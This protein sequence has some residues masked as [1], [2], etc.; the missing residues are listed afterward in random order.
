[1]DSSEISPSD[2]KEEQPAAPLPLPAA[3]L[4]FLG[5]N[6][7]DPMLYSMADTIPRYIR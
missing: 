7:L 6:G 1:M 3:F 4:E 5:E 2:R